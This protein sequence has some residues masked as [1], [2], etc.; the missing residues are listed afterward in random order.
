M[1]DATFIQ[2]LKLTCSD[3]LLNLLVPILN[4][5][6]EN[7]HLNEYILYCSGTHPESMLKRIMFLKP[8]LE[9]PPVH[10]YV[11]FVL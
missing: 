10:E 6:L 7:P 4:H 9:N 8:M 3:L 1:N 11:Y 5:I 2:L